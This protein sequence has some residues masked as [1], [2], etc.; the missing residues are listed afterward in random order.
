MSGY[1][2]LGEKLYT[3]GQAY[4]EAFNFG[5]TEEDAKSV[6]WIVE[7]ITQQ[8]SDGAT[9]HLDGGTHPHEAHYLKLDSSKARAKLGWSSRWRLSHTLQSIIVWHK[10]H[11]RSQ[12]MRALC[13][14][15]INDY[16]TSI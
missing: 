6:Q 15:Q 12:D 5:P 3:Q 1:L 14:Q 2:A 16:S 13:L 9:W 8:W 7:Q 4:A 10:A 11:N